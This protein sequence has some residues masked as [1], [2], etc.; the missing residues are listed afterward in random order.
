MHATHLI[1]YNCAV[2]NAIIL[3]NCIRNSPDESTTMNSPRK[4]DQV[5]TYTSKKFYCECEHFLENKDKILPK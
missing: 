3:R 2:N 1:H 5:D 4:E